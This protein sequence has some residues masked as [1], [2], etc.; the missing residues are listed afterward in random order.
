MMLRLGASMC[1]HYSPLCY[2]DDVL[3]GSFYIETAY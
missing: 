3:A 2:T 1:L